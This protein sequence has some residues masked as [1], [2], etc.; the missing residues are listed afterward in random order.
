MNIS[1]LRLLLWR[2]VF[3]WRVSIATRM[4]LDTQSHSLT[5]T[6][7]PGANFCGIDPF[8]LAASLPQAR[9]LVAILEVLCDV[10][11]VNDSYDA[12]NVKLH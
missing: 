3:A 9:R 8:L 4:W 1:C 12:V 11:S 5:F 6:F 2:K 7:T 10:E